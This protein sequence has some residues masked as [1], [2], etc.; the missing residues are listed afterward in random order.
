M[1]LVSFYFARRDNYL[2]KYSRSL[3]NIK[4]N[5]IMKYFLTYSEESG[6]D[7]C[8]IY[9]RFTRLDGSKKPN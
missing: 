8:V 6:L 1:V 7:Q 5:R 9:A 3:D 4:D 2:G